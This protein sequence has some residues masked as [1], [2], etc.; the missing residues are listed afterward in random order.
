MS[1]AAP[2]LQYDTQ[3]AETLR[4]QR[5]AEI[6]GGGGG[7]IAWIK[8]HVWALSD[9]VLISGT[10]FLT[11]VLTAKALS[12]N[13]AEFGIFSSIYAVLLFSNIFQSTLITQAHNV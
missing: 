4:Q 2:V 5:E 10:N 13:K 3:P 8:S 1:T 12:N 9:Q 11:G 6:S 7:A